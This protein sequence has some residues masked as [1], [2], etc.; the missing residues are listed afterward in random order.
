MYRCSWVRDE[1]FFPISRKLK[2]QP[3]YEDFGTKGEA[4]FK[5]R[6]MQELGFAACVTP[7][8]MPKAKGE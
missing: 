5:K 1:K 4:E 7:T 3:S 8:P 2:P 6:A